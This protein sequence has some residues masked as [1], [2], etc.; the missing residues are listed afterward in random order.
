MEIKESIQDQNILPDELFSLLPQRWKRV[1]GVGILDLRPE[2]IPWRYQIGKIYLSY[3]PE[4]K[5]IAFKA[6]KT[7]KTERLPNFEILAGDQNTVTL[8]KE[9]GCKFWLDAL[10]LT[11]SNS[12]D[13]VNE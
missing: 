6:G 4:L 7:N 5:T 12:Y 13:A 10:K 8:H 9:L 1:G 2:L 11:F 3:L